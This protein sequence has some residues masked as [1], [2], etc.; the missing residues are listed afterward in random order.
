MAR[1]ASLL[2]CATASP[3]AVEHAACASPSFIDRS[4]S[5]GASL[6]GLAERTLDLPSALAGGACDHPGGLGTLLEEMGKPQRAAWCRFI[7]GLSSHTESPGDAFSG[8]EANA[9]HLQPI[10]RSG[11]HDRAAAAGARAATQVRVIAL[12]GSMTAGMG[13]VESVHAINTAHSPSCAYPARLAK[14]LALH[15]GANVEVQNLASGGI[16]TAVSL[17]SLAMLLGPFGRDVRVPTLLLVDYSVNDN[18]ESSSISRETPARAQEALTG[19]VE[20]LV[21]FVLGKYP[22]MAVMLLPSYPWHSAVQQSNPSA[23]SSRAVAHA[24]GLLSMRY[25]NVVMTHAWASGDAWGPN[26]TFVPDARPSAPSEGGNRHC[27]RHPSWRTHQLVADV[28]FLS[29]LSLAERTLC[30]SRPLR[31]HPRKSAWCGETGAAEHVAPVLT[32]RLRQPISASHVLAE[33]DVCDAPLSSFVASEAIAGRGAEPRVAQGNF[34]LFEERRGKPGWITF[35]PVGSSLDFDLRFG[36]RPRAIVSFLRGY[37]ADMGV[38]QVRI[39][40]ARDQDG[41]SLVAA[42]RKLLPIWSRNRARL[43]SRRSDGVEATT[44]AMAQFMVS[45]KH[46]GNYACASYMP[47]HAQFQV[48]TVADARTTSAAHLAFMPVAVFP[49]CVYGVLVC[50]RMPITDA[51][52]AFVIL[53]AARRAGWFW[54]ARKQHRHHAHRARVREAGG[55]RM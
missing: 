54:F 7:R 36:S 6:N 52:L 51:S 39:V 1:F 27:Q 35:G 9:L 10:I 15:F 48:N 11:R 50:A 18:L 37:T 28:T 29:V 46:C 8:S 13:C 12:G 4:L 14:W 2:L 32:P 3:Q 19:A 53:R 30:A 25:S 5:G 40:D 22:H 23:T 38:L 55:L 16:S 43:R 41:K 20:K 45:S 17:T 26:C 42:K 44:A 47:P 34:T 33:F 49:T 21:R 24:Y 31:R